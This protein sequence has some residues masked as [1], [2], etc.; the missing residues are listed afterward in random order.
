MTCRNHLELIRKDL[1]KK[2]AGMIQV[3]PQA[4]SWNSE[5]KGGGGG[6]GG[7]G[8]GDKF[9]II[10]AEKLVKNADLLAFLVHIKHKLRTAD[11]DQSC[12]CLRS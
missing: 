12:K 4:T 3:V 1:Y 5:R 6:G 10:R 9:C 8:G 2:K 7:V 11:Q